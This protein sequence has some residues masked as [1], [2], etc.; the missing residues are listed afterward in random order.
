[1]VAVFADSVE[2]IALF[3]IQLA[4]VPKLELGNQRI[5]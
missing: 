3:P 5:T 1:M 2:V 4:L